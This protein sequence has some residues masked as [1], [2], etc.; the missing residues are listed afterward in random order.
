MT[1]TPLLPST[2]NT[3][4]P[5]LTVGGQRVDLFGDIADENT[6][7]YFADTCTTTVINSSKFKVQNMYLNSC[8]VDGP[9]TVPQTK[10]A[11]ACKTILTTHT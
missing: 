4:M 1:S 11:Y 9:E 8:K 5:D 10:P 6:S 7:Y 2:G 3:N